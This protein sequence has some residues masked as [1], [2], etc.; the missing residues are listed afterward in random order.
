MTKDKKA[1]DSGFIE[2]N[3][4]FARALK[5]ME[6]SSSHVF[7]TGKAGT[8]KS[9]LLQY[10]REHTAKNVVVLAPTGV[11]AL[12][13]GGQTIHSFF[14]F[15]PGITPDTVKKTKIIGGNIFK[16]LDTIIVDEISMV[17]ADLFDCM[18]R[19]LRLHASRPKEPFGGIQM[20]MIGDLYQLPPVVNSQ[21][22]EIFRTHYASPYFFDAKVFKDLPLEFVELEKIYR[23]K[24]AGFISLLNA[25]RNNSVTDED[26]NLLN[27]RTEGRID[28]DPVEFYIC[29]T[30]TNDAADAV[31]RAKLAGLHTKSKRYAGSTHGSF[32]EKYLPTQRDLEVKTGAQVML[33]NN[34]PMGQWVNGSVG[35]V[36]A[37]HEGAGDDG[38][39]LLA[40]ELSNGDIVEVGPHK[41]DIIHFS[42]DKG[43]EKIVSESAGSFT[44]YPVRLAWAVTIHKSQG[45]TFDRVVVDI[46]RGAFASGQVYVALSR[47]TTLEGLVLRKPI[48][49]RHIFVDWK[50]VR[51]MTGFQYGISD[52][53]LPLA[54]KVAM[55]QEA[56]RGKHRLSI[57]YLKDKDEKSRRDIT[58]TKVGE[59]EY[60][61]KRFLG[62]QAYCHSQKS[63][64]VFRV[65]RILEMEATKKS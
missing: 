3:D 51:F 13:V 10:F 56:I 29:L 61:E 4:Y 18:D 62:V 64:R 26:M 53:L 58:P 46:G 49:K 55:I 45:K 42:Y 25:I 48:E 14:R 47:C 60:K 21:E 16:N 54:D 43:E 15:K 9:T 40:I 31:N 38:E 32:D 36:M 1:P 34:E 44:Q 19:F 65:D 5:F 20:V 7:I 50:I 24:D 22:R 37:I 52:R 41:W 30:S 27:K 57:T 59:M 39:D 8:G 33:L 6:K 12:N 28:P 35:R 17:R 23:Q 63:D 11:A 2:I